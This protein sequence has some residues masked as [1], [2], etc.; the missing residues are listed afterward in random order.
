MKGAR[1][2]KA[3]GEVGPRLTLRGLFW[4]HLFLAHAL[5]SNFR[6]RVAGQVKANLHDECR[7][8]PPGRE[9]S[10]ERDMRTVL[11]LWTTSE[12]L[13]WHLRDSSLR[14]SLHCQ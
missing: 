9:R 7:D 6:R 1:R 4:T 13:S 5:F 3:R 10:F 14:L 12:S 11:Q 2:P 8:F